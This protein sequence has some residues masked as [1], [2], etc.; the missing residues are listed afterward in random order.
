MVAAELGFP[1]RMRGKRLLEDYVKQVGKSECKTIPKDVLT[2]S[3]G[4]YLSTENRS[5]P[6]FC[7]Q[8]AASKQPS[9][10]TFGMQDNRYGG[11]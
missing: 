9:P 2:N 7:R 4:L 11:F 1:I 8:N 10:S 5:F 6:F 3:S